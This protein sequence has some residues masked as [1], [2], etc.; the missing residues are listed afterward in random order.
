MDDLG[1]QR[2]QG[3][4]S[5]LE[6][7]QLAKPFDDEFLG[8]EIYWIAVFAS[9]SVDIVQESKSILIKDE[10]MEPPPTLGIRFLTIDEPMPMLNQDAA[11]PIAEVIEH[12]LLS[13][14]IFGHRPPV[15]GLEI[16][17]CRR[18]LGGE[19]DGAEVRQQ[20]SDEGLKVA[21]GAGI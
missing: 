1:Q 12:P 20:V 18:H 17:A 14:T 7:F 8:I 6:P 19:P 3:L 16:G 10:N 9:P 2:N 15:A 5:R 4:E 11:E 13:T 21:H